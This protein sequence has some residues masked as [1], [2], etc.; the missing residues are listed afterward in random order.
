M[1][2]KIRIEAFLVAVGWF[3]VP[4]NVA[5]PAEDGKTVA[6]QEKVEVVILVGGHG[7]DKR[8]FDQLW[9]SYGDIDADVWQGAPYT[10]FDDVS[11]FKY[12]VIVMYNLSSGIT[13]AQRENFLRLLEDGV[14][15]VVW[16]HALANCQDWPEFEKIAG[17]KFWMKPGERNGEQIGR[18]GTGGGRVKMH[19]EDP[20][21]PITKDMDDFEVEDETYNRQT[22]CDGIQ[23]LVST[24]HPRSDKPIAWVHNY[25]KAR[26]F[27]YQSGHDAKVWTDANFQRLMA[28]GIRWT[29]GRLPATAD[30]EE[31]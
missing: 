27:G 26:V 5:Q 22:F 16:H 13:D 3:L 4:P 2:G 23:V 17:A 11:E 20:K 21:H 7:Y 1:I 9:S 14:G 29:A 12:D 15:L 6:A 10:V 8:G 19:I 30:T 18:S 28:R 24:D 31:D 25:R